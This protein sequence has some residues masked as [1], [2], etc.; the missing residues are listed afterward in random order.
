MNYLIKLQKR[1]RQWSDWYEKFVRK[2]LELALHIDTYEKIPGSED[3]CHLTRYD[4]T[5]T[6]INNSTKVV[7]LGVVYTIP[8]ELILVD[9][10]AGGALV[11]YLTLIPQDFGNNP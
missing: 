7:H 5:F 2:S 10:G 11:A 1:E 3:S 4:R 6:E 8:T 9:Q